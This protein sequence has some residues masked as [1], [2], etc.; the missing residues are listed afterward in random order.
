MKD[1][2]SQ[3]LEELFPAAHQARGGNLALAFQVE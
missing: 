2:D 1:W 3:V